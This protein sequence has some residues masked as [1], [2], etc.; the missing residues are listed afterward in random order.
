MFRQRMGTYVDGV[1]WN[2]VIAFWLFGKADLTL[3]S[4]LVSTTTSNSISP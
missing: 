3:F 2:V 4:R 1:D